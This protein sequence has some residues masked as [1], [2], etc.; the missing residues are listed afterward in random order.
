MG[1]WRN[2]SR[3]GL[4]N[5]WE[6]SRVGAIP[7][8]PTNNIPMLAKA[9]QLLGRDRG[10]NF[11]KISVEMISL[12]IS[13]ISTRCV[14]PCMQ[15]FITLVCGFCEKPFEKARKEFD[16][17]TKMGITVF[18]CGLGCARKRP[19]DLLPRIEKHCPNCN[20]QFT[21]I[22]GTREQL[23][24]SQSCSNKFFVRGGAKRISSSYRAICW[25]THRK[26]CVV[27]GESKIVAVHHYDENHENNSI[28]NLI[29]LCPTHHVYIHSKYKYEIIEKV[30]EFRKTV[31]KQLSL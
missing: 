23:T 22:Q 1:V 21:T 25:R 14:I 2:R 11:C 19:R 28:D 16:R 26:A 29:P 7:I 8:T 13:L 31:T 4:R 5:Q 27:C 18:Y 30:E 20:K 17:R 3:A 9:Y 12:F 24:C 10:D 15:P 6:K